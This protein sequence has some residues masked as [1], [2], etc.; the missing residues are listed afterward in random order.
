MSAW[1][2][3][4]GILAVVLAS[5][6]E[7]AGI[8]ALIVGAVCMTLFWLDVRNGPPAQGHPAIIAVIGTF[9]LAFGSGAFLAGF[10]ARRWLTPRLH[11]DSAV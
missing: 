3:Q 10:V 5:L 6:L 11:R 8:G 4:L 9:L 7:V 1:K 2:L